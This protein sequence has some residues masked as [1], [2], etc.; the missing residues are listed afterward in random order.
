MVH[1]F[2]INSRSQSLHVLARKVGNEW[3]VESINGH[4]ARDFPTILVAKAALHVERKYHPDAPILNEIPTVESDI[5]SM[6]Q[7]IAW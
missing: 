7:E 1:L 6:C 3:V 4:A 2:S 5:D